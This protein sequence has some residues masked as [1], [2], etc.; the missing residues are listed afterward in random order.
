MSAV[1]CVTDR[2]TGAVVGASALSM[3]DAV[4]DAVRNHAVSHASCSLLRDA[5]AND[6][7][8]VGGYTLERTALPASVEVP[9]VDEAMVERAA[10]ADDSELA[11]WLAEIG[12]TLCTFDTCAMSSK[13]TYRNQART[14]L[15]AALGG[16]AS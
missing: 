15:T 4:N 5:I 10:I 6:W 13:T 7:K 9:V 1:Y 2:N 16:G 8:E 12:I 11:G 3:D 14:I